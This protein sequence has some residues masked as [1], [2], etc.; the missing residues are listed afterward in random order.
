[1]PNIEIAGSTDITSDDPEYLAELNLHHAAEGTADHLRSLIDSAIGELGEVS[2]WSAVW[3]AGAGGRT[4]LR[5]TFR[6]PGRKEARDWHR[7]ALLAV[8]RKNGK[9]SRNDRCRVTF[10][11]NM[12]P[13]RG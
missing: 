8:Q 11:R 9:A 1:M 7:H 10:L 3:I 12:R 6:A 5:L 13:P 4:T 2:S